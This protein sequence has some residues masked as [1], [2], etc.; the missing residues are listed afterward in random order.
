MIL[1]FLFSVHF[2]NNII[3]VFFFQIKVKEQE[4]E[5]TTNV[6]AVKLPLKIFAKI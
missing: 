4:D 5:V 3:L 6:F 2:N 1:I